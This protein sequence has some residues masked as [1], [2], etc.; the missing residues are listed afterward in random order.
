M[1]SDALSARGRFPAS[2]AADPPQLGRSAMYRPRLVPEARV[3]PPPV[4]NR[5]E[6]PPRMLEP[7]WGAWTPTTAAIMADHTQ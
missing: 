5:F 4:G 7:Q 3:V 6:G 1:R 2:L